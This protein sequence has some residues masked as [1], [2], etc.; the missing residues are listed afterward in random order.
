M[1]IV[2]INAT[3][4]VGST[5][6][7][8][9]G[10]SRLLTAEGIENYVLYSHRTSGYPLG[11]AC[12]GGAYIRFQAL[13]SKLLGN[14]GFNSRKA[15]K[16]MIAQLERISPDVVHLH[17]I[18]G[19]DC[20][21]E[22]LFSYFRRKK[23]KLVWTFHDCWAFTGYCPH[24]TM[25]RCE[26]WKTGCGGC[27]QR[28]GH[29]WL[30][31]RSGTLYEKKRRLFS[32]LDLTIVTP[33][34]WLAGLVGESFLGSYP[35]AVIP[36]GIDLE[37]FKPTPGDF[38]RRHGLT[39]KKLL[40]GVAFG[41]SDQKGLDVFRA[42]ARRLPEDHR[43]VLVG[44]DGQT[45]RGL[46]ENIL[47]IRRTQSQRELAELYTAAD[48]FLNPSREENYPTVNMEA[49]ACGTPVLTFR[50]GGSPEIIDKTCGAVVDWGDV[51]AME[52]EIRRF[53]LERDLT[54]ERCPKRAAAF[55][56][57]ARFREYLELYEKITT[58]A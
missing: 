13:K 57:G 48:L 38:R 3:C 23:T 7:I 39:G 2:Q 6:T 50:T 54:D 44:T 14:Y 8:C 30:F 28:R 33:S 15:T 24:F 17:N 22:L 37:V 5:G 29:S 56:Q 16:K 34:R 46:S 12:S 49:L 43:I 21:L 20:N 36:N 52:R 47:C 41:W 27:V 35:V 45:E 11:I 55:D 4:G 25:A 19:H 58:E 40:L 9:V 51:D 26:K 32:G 18:H 53:F 31:D 42:L 1:K 10:I